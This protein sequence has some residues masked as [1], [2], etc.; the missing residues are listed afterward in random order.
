MESNF[1][2]WWFIIFLPALII[3]IVFGFFPHKVVQFRAKMQQK[4]FEGFKMSDEDIDHSLYSTIFGEN[5]S[6]RL[7][8]QR[9][10]PVEFKLLI[11]LSRVI[12]FFTLFVVIAVIFLIIIAARNGSVIIR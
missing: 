6:K 3:G 11:F 1:S 5:Y 2:Y 4:M 8:A 7:K 9:D 12:G 10:R